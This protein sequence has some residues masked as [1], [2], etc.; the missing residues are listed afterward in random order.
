[1]YRYSTENSER[2]KALQEAGDRNEG[3]GDEEG[4]DVR[5]T[6]SGWGCAS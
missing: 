5:E 4:D 3:G 2:L 1:L 6:V